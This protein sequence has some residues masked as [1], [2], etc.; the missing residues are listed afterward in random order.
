MVVRNVPLDAT[1]NP[2]SDQSNQGG[3]DHTLFIEEGVAIGLV[4]AGE[5]TSADLRRNADLEVFVLQIDQ[6][7]GLVL[8]PAGQGIKQG[9][10]ID[11]PL[12]SLGRPAKVEHG[13]LLRRARD[14]GRN[15]LVLF[16]DPNSSEPGQWEQ[17]RTPDRR[18]TLKNRLF[19]IPA[20]LKNLMSLGQELVLSPKTIP[21]SS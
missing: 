6:A 10:G 2:G 4:H 12:R 14:I 9:I 1:R 18:D 5:D 20:F 7:I 21:K 17:H 11:P 16:P 3:L 8:L 15:D 19:R 13:I